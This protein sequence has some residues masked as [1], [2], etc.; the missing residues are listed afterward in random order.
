MY[1]IYRVYYATL[2]NMEV[3]FIISKLLNEAGVRHG[4]FMRYGG[5]S[6]G[7]FE[8]LNGKKG[9]GDSDENVDEN[10]RRALNAL[11]MDGNSL[12]HIIHGFKDNLLE[13]ATPD[14]YK[15]YDASITIQP[16][17]TLTQ[18]TADCASIILA[19]PDPKVKIV[20]LVHGAW[21]TLNT[22]L[23]GKVVTRF[24]D[25]GADTNDL[26]AGIGPMICKNCYEFGPEA[27]EIF[28]KKYITPKDDKYL[29][30]LKSMAIDQLQSAGVFKIDDLHICTLE[31]ERFFSHRRDGASSGR[32]LTL[33]AL[34]DVI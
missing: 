33:A 3:Q 8:S 13:A 25:L 11:N 14:E 18:T 9:S 5:V 10:R 30:D 31:D 32:M 20:G 24:S 17:L 19:S 21:K 26:V 1:Q 6:D 2:I 29:V 28:D 16:H 7:L 4:W 23:L 15:D 22:S 34:P 27:A 12:A